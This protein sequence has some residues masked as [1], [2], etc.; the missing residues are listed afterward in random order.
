MTDTPLSL[1]DFEFLRGK[2][3]RA[4]DLDPEQVRNDY[5][6][7]SRMLVGHPLFI[8]DL[9]QWIAPDLYES[10][11]IKQPIRPEDIHVSMP[12]WLD[13]DPAGPEPVE[14][15][16]SDVV[17]QV[18]D[19]AGKP[20]LMVGGELQ[21][22]YRDNMLGRL[23]RYESYII[24]DLQV[25]DCRFR[26]TPYLIPILMVLVHTNRQPWYRPGRIPVGAPEGSAHLPVAFPGSKI[27]LLDVGL[28]FHTPFEQNTPS[29]LVELFVHL[30]ILRQH[31]LNL[32]QMLPA[33]PQETIQDRIGELATYAQRVFQAMVTMVDDPS[34]YADRLIRW[35]NVSLHPFWC[36]ILERNIRKFESFEDLMVMYPTV[37][38]AAAQ[39]MTRFKTACREEGLEEGR[40][41]GRAEGHAEGRIEERVDNLLA[42]ARRYVSAAAEDRLQVLRTDLV[43]LDLDRIPISDALR[44]HMDRKPGPDRTEQAALSFLED[45]VNPGTG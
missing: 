24:D 17:A 11:G 13:T 40:A 42:C 44:D 10:L 1:P 15:R 25:R 23:A 20:V 35:V 30:E 38:D 39:V 37:A 45:V 21:A 12:A 28:F 27:F 33:L 2:P 19:D 22:E 4:E 34:S 32:T 41:E 18:M 8:A 7:T 36:G 14:R 6:A 16:Y 29:N 5:D 31:H 9:I 3:W 43:Q 26:E